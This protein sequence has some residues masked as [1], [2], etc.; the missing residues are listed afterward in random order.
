VSTARAVERAFRE[1]AGAVLAGLIRAVRSFDLAEDALQDA[2]ATALERWPAEGVPQNPA[3]WITTTARRKAIDRLR[4][5]TTATHGQ[6]ALAALAALEAEVAAPDD[7]AAAEAARVDDAGAAVDDDRLRLIFTCCHPALSLEA[8]VALTLRT[9]GGLSTPEIARAFLV[10]EATLAQRLVRAQRKIRDAGIPYEVPPADAL[11]ERLGAVLAVVYLVF[12]EGYAASGGEELVRADLCAEA[13]RLG[14][15]LASLLPQPEVQGLL[16]LMLLQDSR[17][18]ARVGPSGE[19]VL[20][21]E[22]DRTR[23]DHAEIAEGTALARRA[24][25]GGPPGPYALQA[26]IAALHGAAA[27]PE[28]TD[29]ARIAALY[30]ELLR[31][32][33]TPVV[34]LNR[35]AAVAMAEGPAAGLALLDA[36]AAAGALDDYYLFHSARAD[37]LRRAGRPVEAAA[38]YETA[39]GLAENAT[40]RA[41]LTR[42]LGAMRAAAAAQGARGRP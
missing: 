21:E 7:E 35:A 9:L 11:P 17:R 27:R 32:S 16:G 15:L 31:A 34:E 5:D 38:A 28:D 20:L 26:A 42:R 33:P 29:W 8:Q 13:I 6:A 10:P 40:T 1:E 3:A 14:R 41:F 18:A 39:L 12:N 19:V 36:L 22:Q 23:W 30:A 37:L 24:A 4:R 25:A 2:L